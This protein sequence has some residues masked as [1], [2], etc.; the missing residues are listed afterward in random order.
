MIFT[1]EVTSAVTSKDGGDAMTEIKA[2]DG[3]EA[4]KDAN[5]DLSWQTDIESRAVYQEI[6]D[7]MGLS[8]Q[9]ADDVE[10]K[11]F[12][13][14]FYFVGKPKAALDKVAKFNGH[15]WS[16]QN[17]IVQI[18]KPGG[19]MG[20]EVYKISAETGMIDSPKEYSEG[21]GKDKKTGLELRILLNSALEVN[22]IVNIESKT[23]NG[24]FIIQKITH[25]GTN[26]GGDWISTLKVVRK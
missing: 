16:I 23:I 22:S 6:A 9:F 8:I 5:F 20:M 3:H 19:S 25:A 13:D 14:N 12:P 18:I 2:F 26:Y 17:E 7:K 11:T 10:F 1:G 15:E 4:L 24:Y 21:E